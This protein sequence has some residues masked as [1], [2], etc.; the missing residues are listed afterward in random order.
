MSDP[1]SARVRIV[2]VGLL[3]ALGVAW[4]VVAAGALAPQATAPRDQPASPA[5]HPGTTGPSITGLRP[6][7]SQED[8][9]E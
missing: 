1:S 3:A 4:M 9:T 6:T 5:D 2:P 7:T 8:I